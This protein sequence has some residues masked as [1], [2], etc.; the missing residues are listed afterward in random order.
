MKL[1]RYVS[2]VRSALPRL[3]PLMRDQRVPQ[4]LKTGTVIGAILIVSPLDLFGDIPILGIL[5]DA[6]LLAVL[7]TIFVNVATRM[8]PQTEERPMRVVAPTQ[9][10]GAEK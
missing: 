1:L 2:A 3:L 5:D 10:P 9:L 4:W 7:A 8:L 6:A